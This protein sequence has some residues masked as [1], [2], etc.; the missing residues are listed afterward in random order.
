MNVLA[1]TGTHHLTDDTAHQVF[2]GF[3]E[4]LKLLEFQRNRSDLHFSRAA[5]DQRDLVN[6]QGVEKNFLQFVGSRSDYLFAA[7]VMSRLLVATG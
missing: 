4:C 2:A 1:L 5:C 3:A 6:C 7:H